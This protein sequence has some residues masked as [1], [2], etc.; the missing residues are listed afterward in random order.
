[1][2]VT[3][4]EV[5]ASRI[6]MLPDVVAAR[7]VTP[8]VLEGYETPSFATLRENVEYPGGDSPRWDAEPVYEL[9]TEARRRFADGSPA[10]SDA[11]LAPRLH[12][13]MRLTRG[14]ASDTRIWNFLGVCLAPG[15]VRWRWGRGGKG[16]EVAQAARFVGRWDLQ[17]FSRL[18]W[19]AELFRDGSNYGPAQLACGNQDI[20]NTTMRQEMIQHRPAAQALLRLMHKGPVRTGRDVNAATAAANAAGATLVFEA[21]APDEPQDAEALREWIDSA[22]ED[23]PAQF[24]TL[25]S[26]PNDGRVPHGSAEALT[27]RFGELFADAPVRGKTDREGEARP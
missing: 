24:D 13:T 5:V 12:Y 4:R 11:W 14:E 3:D 22:G 20:L 27:V 23:P 18:W 1:M 7:A 9:L 8:R 21:L 26:G 16:R 17:C 10:L 6:G 25:P 19:A 2:R 15:F